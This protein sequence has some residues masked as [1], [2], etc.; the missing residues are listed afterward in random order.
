MSKDP[1]AQLAEE[2]NWLAPAEEPVQNAVRSV[3]QSLGPDGGRKVR[4]ALHGTW[5]HEPLHAVLTDIPVGSW[6]AAV[7]FDAIAML[8]G[9]RAFD[10]AADASVILGLVGAAGAAVTGL[11][12]WADLDGAPRRIGMVHGLLNVSAVGLFLTSSIVRKRGSRSAGRG[13][14]AL[15]YLIASASAHLGGNLVYEH[16]VGVESSHKQSSRGPHGVVA[17]EGGAL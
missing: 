14:A 8:G 9:S 16:G 7:V 12:D 5:L 11:N 4:D 1:V 17:G 3:F 15:G 13:W 6:T 2:Q 10:T